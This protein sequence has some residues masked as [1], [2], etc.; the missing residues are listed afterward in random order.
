MDW[1]AFDGGSTLGE[2]GS[3]NG[4]IL[5]DEE[6]PVG[7][8]ITLERSGYTAP[9]SITCGVYGALV[10]TRFFQGETEALGDFTEMKIQLTEMASISDEAD[11]N[12]AAKAFLEQFP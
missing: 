3:E 5:L 2:R 9:F 12:A 6:H 10:H 11:L 8:R 7:A 1:R 4:V